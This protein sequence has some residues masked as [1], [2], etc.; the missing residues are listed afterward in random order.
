MVVNRVAFS[1]VEEEFPLGRLLME[2]ADY[3]NEQTALWNSLP[4]H[5]GDQRQFKDRG[6]F[7]IRP[8]NFGRRETDEHNAYRGPG[9]LQ[10][11]SVPVIF[12]SYQAKV[13]DVWEDPELDPVGPFHLLAVVN[14]LD[15]AGDL[16]GRTGGQF[17][18]DERRWFGEGRLIFGLRSELSPGVPYPM[19]IIM[20]YRLPA[21]M[22]DGDGGLMEDPDF[23]HLT[24]PANSDE[25]KAGRARWAALWES[26]SRLEVTSGAYQRKLL[27]IVELFAKGKNHLALRMGERVQAVEGDTVTLTGEFEYREFY[28][29]AG[30]WELFTRKLRRE[31]MRCAE[32][33]APLSR[34]VETDWNASLGKL[35]FDYKLGDRNLTAAEVAEVVAGC[36]G[37][38]PYGQ[39]EDDGGQPCQLNARFT[40]FLADTFVWKLQDRGEAKRHEFAVGTCAGC[41]SRETQTAGFHVTPRLVGQDSSLSTFLTG[42]A[43]FTRGGVTYSYSELADRVEL[44]RRFRLSQDVDSPMLVLP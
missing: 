33:S 5:A 21:L 39:C 37:A 30:E 36:G 7:A 35:V 41:H 42:G 10:L 9:K 23:N 22:D 43:S 3:V 26:L 44:M 32:S 19:T 38:L 40:R 24:G 1:K 28:L 20:E 27:G 11:G 15:L 14:R 18:G 31:P 12:N 4:E 25:W 17:A 8:F 34:R 2:D 6:E 29:G 16:D 13:T